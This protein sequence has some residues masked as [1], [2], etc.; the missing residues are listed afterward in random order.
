MIN[1]DSASGPFSHSENSSVRIMYTVIATLMPATVYGLFQ[2]GLNSLYVVLV[3]VIVAVV[4]EFI[5]LKLLRKNAMAS[6]DGSA[7]LTALLL[8][9]SLPPTAPLWL[10]AFGVIF[11]IVVGKQIYGGLGQNLFNPAMLARV[12]LLICFPI[13][14]THWMDPS[15]IDLSNNQ[16]LVPDSWVAFDGV[17]SATTLSGLMKEPA[18]LFSMIF[19]NQ[20]GSLGETSALLIVLGGLFMLYKRIIHWAIPVSFILGLGIPAAIGHAVNPD[21][22]LSMGVSL[23]SGGAMLGAFYIATDL[24]TSPT[25]VKGQ[26]LYGAGCGLLIW[27]IRTFGNY[28]EGV[29]FAVLIMNSASPLIDHYLRPSIFGSRSVME[30]E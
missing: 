3:S 10:C 21:Q 11:A 16:I 23:F 28:P 20:A 26:L 22:Y 13:E 18:T 8:A 1:Y 24:V 9:M 29:A 12:M 25:S 19:G 6:F 7:I 15:P 2:F 17:S 5:C 14:M 27:L 30:K 4:T